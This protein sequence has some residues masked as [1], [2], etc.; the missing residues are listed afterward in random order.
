M[1][2][3]NPIQITNA[4]GFKH[5][6]SFLLIIFFHVFIIPITTSAAGLSIDEIIEDINSEFD[7]YFDSVTDEVR[8]NQHKIHFN[9]NTR[10]LTYE[11]TK[12]YFDVIVDV[13]NY[14]L[15][16]WIINYDATYSNIEKQIDNQEKY[17]Y[18]Y[19]MKDTIKL[20]HTNPKYGIGES[21]IIKIHYYSGL[22]IFVNNM[23][24][25]QVNKIGAK[26]RHLLT[27]LEKIPSPSNDKQ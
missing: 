22:G 10:V 26:L 24:L 6:K 21:D 25:K 20:T 11:K 3:T 7:I 17:F 23:P 12:L 18:I 9:S 5:N 1:I 2:N 8:V 4:A 13:F 19:G 16:P 15:L 14:K 27:K